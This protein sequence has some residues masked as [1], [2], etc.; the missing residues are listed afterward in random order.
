MADLQLPDEGR[1]I[2]QVNWLVS[3]G[4]EDLIDPIADEYEFHL[5]RFRAAEQPAA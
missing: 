1:Y 4:R 2:S 5:A 3:T